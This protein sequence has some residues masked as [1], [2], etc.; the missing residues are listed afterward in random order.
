[1]THLTEASTKSQ[2]CVTT[3]P[4]PVR[5]PKPNGGLTVAV[6]STSRPVRGQLPQVPPLR[7]TPD[8]TS[9]PAVSSAPRPASVSL[10]AASLPEPAS[11]PNPGCASQNAATTSASAAT[12]SPLTV[13]ALTPF[14]LTLAETTR[15]SLG[16]PTATSGSTKASASVASSAAE[17]AVPGP[18]R[19]EP[20]ILDPA[21]SNVLDVAHEAAPVALTV[22]ITPIR[23]ENDESSREVEVE[24]GE[25]ALPLR[26]RSAGRGRTES[27]IPSPEVR[28]HVEWRYGSV[29]GL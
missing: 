27:T 16:T 18:Y 14:V 12:P 15:I 20:L 5:G 10:T 9:A 17:A 4:S 26:P 22:P 2:G 1:M 21:E 13:V 23:E 3:G 25:A 11:H 29:N 24:V 6:A 7:V 28:L 19:P 8:S